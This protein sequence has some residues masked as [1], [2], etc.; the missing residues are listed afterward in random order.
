MLNGLENVGG[1]TTEIKVVRVGE[2]LFVKSSICY[3][4]YEKEKPY[5]T[6]TW[7]CVKFLRQ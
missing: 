1:I 7:G 4:H 5:E 3:S 2:L 6:F